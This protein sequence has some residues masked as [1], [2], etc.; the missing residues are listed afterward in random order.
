MDLLSV[1][2]KYRLEYEIESKGNGMRKSCMIVQRYCMLLLYHFREI[3]IVK[4]KSTEIQ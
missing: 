4:E 2:N 1:E 3:D